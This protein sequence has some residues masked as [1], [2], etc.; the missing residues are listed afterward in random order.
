MSH[1]R[2]QPPRGG[3]VHA[4]SEGWETHGRTFCGR[5][6]NGWTVTDE[7]PGCVRCMQ[8]VMLRSKP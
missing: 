4:T 6:A 2:L 7:V 1:I 8:A 5:K 3:K